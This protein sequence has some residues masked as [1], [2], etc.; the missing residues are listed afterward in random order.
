M[1][2]K[3]PISNSTHKFEFP[4]YHFEQL[5]NSLKVFYAERHDSSLFNLKVITKS[6]A[7][8]DSEPGLTYFTAQMTTKGT[9]S[10]S[11]TKLA[12]ELDNIGANLNAG[13]GW[14][15]AYWN[16]V[17]LGEHSGRAVELLSDCIYNS[18]FPEKEIAILRNRITADISQKKAEPSYLAKQAFFSAIYENSPYGNPITGNE[19]NLSQISKNLLFQRHIALLKDNDISIIA[20]ASFNFNELLNCINQNFNFKNNNYQKKKSNFIPPKTKTNLVRIAAKEDAGQTAL[21]IGK[22]TVG[23][24]HPDYIPLTLANTIFGA[25]FMSRLNALIREKLGYTY[26]IHSFIDYRLKGSTFQIVSSVNKSSTSKSISSIFKLM[27]KFSSQKVEKKEFDRAKQYSLGTFLRN[28]ESSQQV[29]SLLGIIDLFKLKGDY[30]EQ[31]YKKISSL[32]IDDI[33]EVQ[34]KYFL[35]EKIVIAASGDKDYLSKELKNF[36]EISYFES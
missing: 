36:G 35:P 25:Y 33:Y 2:L 28:T 30:Y 19:N 3:P 29:M 32:T 6:G 17:C 8:D 27:E 13:T 26:G 23:I 14:D 24:N 12:L 18:I 16:L 15:S 4:K 11:Q 5:S 20:S 21:R 22:I 1:K 10:K 9:K 31:A 7:F 34:K